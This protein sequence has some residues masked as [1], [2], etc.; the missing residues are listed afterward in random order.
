M[1]K[2]KSTTTKGPTPPK[3]KVD[4][5]WLVPLRGSRSKFVIKRTL[6]K[7]HMEKRWSDELK[8]YVQYKV[9][10]DD[11]IHVLNIDLSL[12]T[13]GIS[14][15]STVTEFSQHKPVTQDFPYPSRC[16]LE[17]CDVNNNLLYS[18][19]AER[20]CRALRAGET[21]TTHVVKEGGGIKTHFK[22][23]AKEYIT[24]SDLYFNPSRDFACIYLDTETFAELAIY[25]LSA[26]ALNEIS[27]R[28]RKTSE[29]PTYSEL[30]EIE[31]IL[32][33][34]HRQYITIK[35]LDWNDCVEGEANYVASYLRAC[36]AKVIDE[37]ELLD[38]FGSIQK[39][40]LCG[41]TLCFIGAEQSFDPMATFCYDC[42]DS[43]GEIYT[44][45]FR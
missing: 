41:D 13:T 17:L 22:Y 12:S 35:D 44:A 28:S 25:H 33:C 2:S 7:V 9:T 43:R 31:R 21:Q 8:Q 34:K 27:D 29:K 4:G 6:L 38:E 39:L 19:E 30:D 18:N 10:V 23:E 36:Q 1:S 40:T 16:F 42:V 26:K 37:S 3:H 24:Y 11:K 5:D 45:L 15:V 32:A 20:V 14:M